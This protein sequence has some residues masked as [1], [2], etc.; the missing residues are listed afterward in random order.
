MAAILK[1]LITYAI[2]RAAVAMGIGIISYTAVIYAVRQGLVYSQHF[3]NQLPT[4]LL[5]FFALSG[6]PNAMSIICGACI[7]AITLRFM[8]R[9]AFLGA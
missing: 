3:Y 6:L 8:S 9:I 2:V 4:E 5:Q 7:A 1:M